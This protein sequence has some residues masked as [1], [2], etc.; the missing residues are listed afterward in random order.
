MLEPWQRELADPEEPV[1]PANPLHVQVIAIVERQRQAGAY[2]LIRND[3]VVDAR[4]WGQLAIAPVEQ[5][6]AFANDF[7]DINRADAPGLFRDGEV[8]EGLLP[9]RIDLHQDDMVRVVV[10]HEGFSEQDPI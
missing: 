5:P 9:Q 10:T 6:T 4:D 1:G 3:A 7:G 8:R 2:E